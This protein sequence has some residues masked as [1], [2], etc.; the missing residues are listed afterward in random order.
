M[1]QFLRGSIANGEVRL[2]SGADSH[3]IVGLARANC[4]VVIGEEHTA[5]PAGAQVPVVVLT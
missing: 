1:R 5:L 3:L 2:V 4:L